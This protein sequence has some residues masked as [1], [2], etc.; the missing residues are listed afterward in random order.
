MRQIGTF[1]QPFNYEVTIEGMLDAR[2]LVPSLDDLLLFDDTNYM[3]NGMLVSVYDVD[4]TKRGVYRLA[5]NTNL[6]DINSWVKLVESTDMPVYTASNGTTLVGYDFQF[7]GQ[8]TKDTSIQL[9]GHLLDIFSATSDFSIDNSG[10]QMTSNSTNG[11]SNSIIGTTNGASYLSSS[12]NAG[13][14]NEIVVS[15][16]GIIVT[17][18]LNTFGIKYRHD[19]SVNGTLNDRWIPDWG[20][21][22]AYTD[23]AIGGT[24]VNSFN[25]RTGSITLNSGDVTTALGYTPYNSSNPSNYLTSTSA[26]LLYQPLENQRLST[27]NSPN[28]NALAIIGTGGSGFISLTAQTSP[29]TTPAVGTQ[30]I[31]AD[32]SGRFTIMGSNGYSASLSK[33]L[34]TQN[35]VYSFPNVASG[36]FAMQTTTVYY[37]SQQGCISD[38]NISTG[39]T[40]YGTDN[41]AAVQAVLNKAL[42]NPIKIIWDGKYSTGSLTI[43]SNTLIEVLDGCG[44][45]LISSTNAPMFRNANK[46][47]TGT[48][49]D[50][51]ISINGGIWNFNGTNQLHN[52]TPEGF[53]VGFKFVGVSNL[54]LN[55]VQ[56][57]NAKT[58]SFLCSNFYNVWVNNSIVD[59]GTNSA[60]NADGLHFNGPGKNVW[61]D[62]VEVRSY[63]DGIAFNADDVP[64]SYESGGYGGGA[65]SNI[66]ITNIILHDSLFGIRLLSGASR[67]DGVTI[68]GLKGNTQGYAIICDN[69]WQ[70]PASLGSTGNGNFGSIVINDVNV[71]V[72]SQS[73]IPTLK[74]GFM[75][76]IGVFDSIKITNVTRPTF[77]YDAPLI[78]TDLSYTNIKSLS[79]SNISSID[80]TGTATSPLITLN[81]GA[82]NT[83]YLEDIYSTKTT[84][85]DAP[86]VL[87]SGATVNNIKGAKLY[88]NGLLNHI[89]ITSGSV[90]NIQLNNITCLNVTASAGVVSTSTTI[91]VLQ[92][93]SFIGNRPSSGAGVITNNTYDDGSVYNYINQ[94]RHTILD[95]SN[96][97]N[98][99]GGTVNFYKYLPTANDGSNQT[100]ANENILVKEGSFN[101][102]RGGGMLSVYYNNGSGTVTNAHGFLGGI[103]NIGTGTITTAASLQALSPTASVSNAIGIIYGL[104]IQAQKVTGVTTG[105]GISQDG[106]TDINVF[107]GSDNAFAGPVR[108]ANAGY[109]TGTWSVG[110]A[111]PIGQFTSDRPT[112]LT[113]ALNDLSA[114]SSIGGMAGSGNDLRQRQWLRRNTAS[115]A[116]WTTV[117][118]H[119]GLDVDG[120]FATPGTNTKT[121]VERNPNAGTFAWGSAA[122]T[123]LSLSSS[124]LT[125]SVPV[126]LIAGTT[127]LTMMKFTTGVALTSQVA[128]STY[129]DGTNLFATNGTTYNQFAYLASPTFTGTPLAPTASL[130]TNTTQLATTAF[131]L[132]NSILNPMTTLGDVIY[133]G[134][135]GIPT[136]LAIGSTGQ[137]LGISSGIPSWVTT[138][139]I[140]ASA[141]LVAQTAAGNVTTFTVGAST[142]TFSIASYINVTAVA[143]DVIQGQITYTDENNTAQTVSLAS[144]SAIGNSTYSPIIIRAKNATV[145]TVKTNLT[146]G[147]G[148][149]TFD[150][151]ARIIQL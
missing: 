108:I 128:G 75:E 105:Y 120:S 146:T 70:N 45:I 151:G 85:L 84:D 26:G 113:T 73:A 34:L 133:G 63:D 21:V 53:I 99:L 43:Y 69:F 98:E 81:N 19:Y 13:N 18:D 100:F 46:V 51:N 87:V 143:V 130:G 129:W 90:V 59:V 89:K 104:R 25:T 118:L 148:S 67:I 112:A 111:T 101:Q 11:L 136:R 68:N 9:Q 27:T 103:S 121:W 41:T 110:T 71:D 72:Q 60:I 74:K 50:T 96:A 95:W 49:V 138:S 126:I 65:I 47:P 86:L 131:V 3:P 35:A 115:G 54:S 12:L 107:N 37:L 48:I 106:T 36:T 140:A 142:A 38:A 17:D 7:G 16:S 23:S 14:G 6:S 119:D 134:T 40:T 114:I 144:L 5:D 88:S 31:Y 125:A 66:N 24:V 57:L 102:S 64:S 20:A 33:S 42:I 79:V 124:G 91:T 97:R 150:T 82:I 58:F 1:P 76:F 2:M 56:L 62:N 52:T 135:S 15:I 39:S 145:I 78:L 93:N 80:L 137:V 83:L 132:A 55:N 149:I 28:F 61:I 141:D 30:N 122:N 127:T 10:T 44:A 147:A 139:V 116:S 32:S 4:T 22:K 77:N 117:T 94:N 109:A 123:Y 8:L 92:L 29:P